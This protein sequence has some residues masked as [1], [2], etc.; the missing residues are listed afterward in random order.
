MRI[1]LEKEINKSNFDLS[2]M[3]NILQHP[4]M[5]NIELSTKVRE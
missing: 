5:E 2:K 3:T 1:I 4:K